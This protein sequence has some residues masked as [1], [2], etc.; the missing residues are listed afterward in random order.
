M[1]EVQ[2]Q[3]HEWVQ[4]HHEEMIETWRDIV[5]T[6]SHVSKRSEGEL[7]CAKLRGIFDELG[8]RTWVT[9][10]C[11]KNSPTLVGIWGENRPGKP[12]LFSGHYDTV[13]LP[14]SHPF[15]FEPD[16][17]VKGLGALDMKGG[18]A[19]TIAVVRCLQAIGWAER[20]VKILFAGDEEIGHEGGVA[21]ETIEKEAAGCLCA[22]NMETGLPSNDI[23]VSR[24]GAAFAYITTKGVASHSGA[25]FSAGRN[26]IVETAYKILKI[27]DLTDL[28]QGTSV[29]CNLIKGGTVINSVPDE[30]VLSVDIR[31]EK[32]S[33]RGR[34]QKAI[35]EVVA[36]T[37]IDGCSSTLEF[38][39]HMPP[40]EKTAEGER[41]A[42][43]VAAV[44]EEC[45]L[46]HMGKTSLGG[47]S[48]AS[49]IVMAGTPAICSMGVCGEF[50]HTAKEY[51]IPETLFR[52]AELMANVVTRIAAFEK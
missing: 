14:G 5:D 49:H 17:R 15:R 45:G 9:E 28:S 48:D 4:A 11:A 1:S 29:S 47:G 2:N 25:A 37:V 43:F 23:C 21:G 36:E 27:K 19:I 6:V 50:N 46:G 38:D 30:C 26:A 52:R 24:K 35:E 18:I 31:Y 41:L 13:D 34:I 3:I 10:S 39:E 32:L 20:P 8:F 44:S 7:L 22:F 40:F 42:E 51:A 33:E 12:V 16:G